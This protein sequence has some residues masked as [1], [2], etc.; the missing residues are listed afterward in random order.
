MS[1][2]PLAD[3]E[4]MFLSSN[5]PPSSKP[6]HKD[7]APVPSMRIRFA[8]QR[9]TAE[10]ARFIPSPDVVG[11]GKVRARGEWAKKSVAVRQRG[12]GWAVPADDLESL[13]GEEREGVFRALDFVRDCEAFENVRHTSTY[14]DLAPLH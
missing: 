13:V 7:L 10:I 8:R 3:I 11:G 5:L 14:P 4:V 6:K 1:N 2:S 12:T 9:Q